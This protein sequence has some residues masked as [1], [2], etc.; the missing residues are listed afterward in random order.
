VLQ[1]DARC[2]ASSD[3]RLCGR[4]GL[5]GRRYVTG[6]TASIAFPTTAGAFQPLWRLQCPIREQAGSR[7]LRRACW[8]DEP[9]WQECLRVVQPVWNSEC[10]CLR[11]ELPER[12]RAPGCN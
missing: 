3:R 5:V 12:E 4:A 1:H 11:F 2:A 7:D 10:D 8:V 6:F 9:L